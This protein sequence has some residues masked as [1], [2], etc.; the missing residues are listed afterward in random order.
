MDAIQWLKIK[1]LGR[2]SYGTVHLAQSRNWYGSS[3]LM[4]VKSVAFERSSSLKKEAQILQE[5]VDCPQVVRGL[6]FDVTLEGGLW[7]YN[8]FMEY[9]PGGT[10]H[11]LIQRSGGKLDERDVQK[12]TRMILK[13]LRCIHEK[14]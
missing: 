5:F 9:A 11:D 8:L 3:W 4:A 10:L 1:F 12:F 2:G 7:F 13:G 14:G 6:G